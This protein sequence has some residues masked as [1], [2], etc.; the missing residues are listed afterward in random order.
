M[1]QVK[2]KLW[3]GWNRCRF[4]CPV[5]KGRGGQSCGQFAHFERIRS[6]HPSTDRL[7]VSVFIVGLSCGARSVLSS[8]LH[9]MHGAKFSSIQASIPLRRSPWVH[10]GGG[11]SEHCVPSTGGVSGEFCPAYYSGS[12][13]DSLS[14]SFGRLLWLGVWVGMTIL[15]RSVDLSLHRAKT[16]KLAQRV[17][18]RA[19]VVVSF[20]FAGSL[21]LPFF[22]LFSLFVCTEK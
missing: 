5:G 12:A 15:G 18:P 9:K 17:F 7:E 1:L 11:E 14:Q 6:V 10:F 22:L 13:I 19:Q 20:F 21:C 8:I 3:V 4:R 16:E 2:T